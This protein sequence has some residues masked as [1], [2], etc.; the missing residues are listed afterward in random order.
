MVTY[1][2]IL[3]GLFILNTSHS[4][5]EQGWLMIMYN[6]WK[7]LNLNSNAP[8]RVPYIGYKKSGD[9]VEDSEPF[10]PHPSPPQPP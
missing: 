8:D 2:A 10:N 9:E 1:L 4:S 7:D 5:Q 3:K 6:R